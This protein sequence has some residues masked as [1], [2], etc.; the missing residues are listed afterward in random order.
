[1]PSQSAP[2]RV[3]SYGPAGRSV[4]VLHGGPGAPGSA[5]L[6]ARDLSDPLH[7]LEPWQRSSGDVPLT[8][9]R[10]VEDLA[11][12]LSRYT[13]DEKPALVGESWGA[14]LALAF[15]ARYPDRIGGL[16]LVGCGTFDRPSRE[17]L[18]ETIERRTSKALRARLN[19][20][21]QTIPDE[22][23]RMRVAHEQ[24]D[25][26]YTYRRI[27]GLEDPIESVDP[28]GHHETWQ[29]MVRLQESGVYPAELASIR[30][31]VLMLHGSWDPH[32]G[33]MI[34][35]ALADRIPQLE[36]QELD[37][38]GHSPWVEEQARD[39]FLEIA[40]GWLEQP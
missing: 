30:C 6:L 37:H 25:P 21:L 29:D 11:E 24:S 9:D 35:D 13:P 26:I 20:L 1:M 4:Y 31:P 5:A 12:V 3:R 15:A 14:M 38:C 33:S 19:A 18:E 10:H 2:L 22:E 23:V 17:Q 36:Y 16:L 27:P 39:R 7:V 34:R 32:P 28:R 8:V 40:R